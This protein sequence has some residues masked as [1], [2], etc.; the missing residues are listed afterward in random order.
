MNELNPRWPILPYLLLA[1]GLQM[2]GA[3]PLQAETLIAYDAEPNDA[4]S[5]AVG[6]RLPGQ[7]DSLQVLGELSGQDQDAYRLVVD[8]DQA[9]RR[10]SLALTGRAGALTQLDLFDFSALVDDRGRVPEVLSE[11]PRKLLTLKATDGS[12]GAQVD[13]LL[14]PP[15]VY[16]LGVSHSGGEGAYTIELSEYDRARVEVLDPEHSALEPVELRPGRSE[17]ILARDETWFEVNLSGEQASGFH[18]LEFQTAL[19][20]SARAE[21]LDAN[22]SKL[23]ELVTDGGK[24]ELRPGL[25]LAEGPYRI[26]VRQQA[27]G[28][29]WLSLPR[30]A[31]QVVDGVERE[32][33]DRQPMTVPFGQMIRGRFDANDRELLRFVVDDETAARRWDL[34]VRG[35]PESRIEVC[36]LRTAIGMQDCV[37]GTGEG[38]RQPS[39]GFAPGEYQIRLSDAGPD[40]AEWMLEWEDRGPLSPGGESEPNDAPQLASPL[41]ERGFGR[42]AFEGGRET[43]HWRFN[44]SGEP[45][46]WRIQLQGEALHE[47]ALKRIGGQLIAKT[48]AAGAPRVRIENAFLLPGEYLIAA[49]GDRGGYTVRVQP[50]GPPPEGMEREPNDD[51]GTA[52]RLRF[53]QEYFGLLAERSDEDRYRFTLLGHEQIRLVMTPPAGSRYRTRIGLG[54]EAQTLVEPEPADGPDQPVEWRGFLPPGDYTVLLSAHET[55]DDEYRLVVHRED[56]L[57]PM[58]DREPNDWIDAASPFPAD[59]ILTGQL[60]YRKSASDW[61]RLPMLDAPATI[62]LPTVSGQKYEVVALDTRGAVALVHDREAGLQLAELKAGVA[63]AVHIEGRGSYRIDLGALVSAPPS[64]GALPELSIDLPGHVLQAFSPWAQRLDGAVLVTN[65]HDTSVTVRLEAALTDLRWSLTGLLPE[66]DLAPGEQRRLPFEIHVAPDAVDEPDVQ[67]SVR[68]HSG[69]ASTGAVATLRTSIDAVP[70][71]PGFHWPVPDALRGGFNAA[72]TRFGSRMVASPNIP[73]DKLDDFVELFD[74]LTRYGRWTEAEMKTS[75]D[76]VHAH[77]QPTVR[78]AGDAP[79]PVRGFLLNPTSTMDTRAMLREFEVALSMDGVDFRTV[80]HG[81]LAPLPMEQGFVLDEVVPA[82]YARLIPINGALGETRRL[83]KLKLGEFKVVADPAWRPPGGP[84]NLADPV[85][86]GHLVWANP[87][88]RGSTFDTTVLLADGKSPEG[89]IGS[90][91]KATLVIGFEHARAA[92]VAA[93]RIEAN[94]GRVGN[95]VQAEAVQ[96]LVSESSPI[97]PWRKVASAPI[98]GPRVD[99]ALDAPERARYLRFDFDLPGDARAMVYPDRVL[100]FEADGPSVLGEWG[101]QAPAG[102]LEADSPPRPPTG[103]GAPENHSRERAVTLEPGIALAGSALLDAYTSWYH[104]PVSGPHNRLELTLEGRPSLEGAP[105]LFD[106]D[107]APVALYALEAS[108]TEARWEAWVTPGAEY[109]LEVFEPPRSVIFSWDTSGSVAH[110][111]PTISNAL[112]SYAESVRPGRDEVNLLPFGRRA[113]L[114]DNWQGH[115]Y[116]LVRMMTMYTQEGSVSDAEGALAAA[117]RAL[118]GRPGKKAVLLLTDAATNTEESLWPSLHRGRPQVFAM[119]LS[120]EG[121]FGGGPAHEVDLMQDWAMVRGGHFHYVTGLGDLARGFDRTIAWLK[122]PVYFTAGIALSTVEDPAPARLSI[123]PPPDAVPLQGAVEIILDASGSMLKRMQGQRRIDVAKSAIREA[124]VG[125]LPEGLPVAL[126]VYGHREA[127]TCR[128]DLE[129][130]V[131]PLD[132]AAFLRRVEPIQA[133]NLARTPIADS[134][135]AVAD[136]LSAVEGRKLVVLLTDGEETCDGDPKAVIET[137]NATDVDVRIN[138]VGFALEDDAVKRQFAE[139]A[140]LGGGE[141]LDA[142]DPD[143]LGMAL[144]RAMEVPFVVRD[145]DGNT[146]ARGVVGG[147]PVELPPGRYEVSVEG[148]RTLR[149]ADLSLA[150]GE[151]REIRLD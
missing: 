5:R 87:W 17:V 64:A 141:Y 43:D 70:V 56:A 69:T 37:R 47:L 13:A 101:H 3:T 106:A 139:W 6:L 2:Y 4:P 92:R 34:W 55:S 100:A 102:P 72:A 23:L 22:D 65:P 27:P 148:A 105:R 113:P 119:K 111:L 149:I 25:K 81:E 10:F 71:A 138:I 50:L 30:G 9:G 31:P 32:P 15:G 42:G 28:L 84:L 49:I 86:G 150:A 52:Q 89:R 14:L 103:D 44:V 57:Q 29:L 143:E 114:L 12:R 124:V 26:R 18:D 20:V 7:K 91:H 8:E 117:A 129:L 94:T 121:A 75:G 135:A 90:D 134:L 68:V 61:Y 116:P 108:V 35:G 76:G 19:G 112:I 53:G 133:I 130:P 98:E 1:F 58:V 109:W 93:V 97:G 60:G 51:P 36:V 24:P 145:A 33:N 96:V 62:A 59:G 38:T 83:Q 63:H 41:H 40:G 140:E 123:L 118:E 80:L 73:D 82:R 54:D 146:V 46:L 95:R 110:W 104:V 67:L 120:S 11:A 79:V 136:D 99:V 21:L 126:R 107:G 16:V 45:Q 74:G 66:L 122:R 125:A 144:R 127:G 132:K 77:Q 115:P 131:A 147:E 85:N 48:Q 142:G 128:T 151:E 137:L 88:I 39:L 78:L